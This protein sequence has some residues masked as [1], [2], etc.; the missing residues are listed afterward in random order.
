VSLRLDWL[1]QNSG[2]FTAELS[3][4]N[5]PVALCQRASYPLR[6]QAA[7]AKG[8]SDLAL[9]SHGQF[10]EANALTLLE[11]GYTL[12]AETVENDT[13]FLNDTAPL[14]AL[15]GKVIQNYETATPHIL[16]SDVLRFFR[17]EGIAPFLPEET[18]TLENSLLI[19]LPG[20]KARQLVNAMKIEGVMISN[21]EG[22]SLDLGQPSF[23]LQ[24]YGFSE[25]EAR[26]AISL[27]WAPAQKEAGFYEALEKLLFRYRQIIR[28]NG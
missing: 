22:C 19:R 28:L 26:E 17:Q 13:F 16:R 5:G 14:M 23:V 27:S 8:R 4:I 2:D 1:H 11:S 12:V 9:F 21:G 18:P 7:E 6:M 15:G 20:I 3:Q 25:D 24:R 10:N